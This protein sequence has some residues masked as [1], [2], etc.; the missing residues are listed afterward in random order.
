MNNQEMLEFIEKIYEKIYEKTKTLNCVDKKELLNAKN[1]IIRVHKET[2][3]SKMLEN[4]R[5]RKIINRIIID[6]KSNIIKLN[7]SLSNLSTK[8]E[9]YQE[10]IDTIKD[11]EQDIKDYE[12][13][14]ADL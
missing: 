10:A 7:I 13:R 2:R 3:M 14:L 11:L 1:N 12:K 9:D 8:D 5:Q 6:N 4:H